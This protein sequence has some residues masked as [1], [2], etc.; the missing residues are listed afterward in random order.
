MNQNLRLSR[1][2]D[3]ALGKYEKIGAQ[4]KIE[5][6]ASSWG[7]DTASLFIMEND[8]LMDVKSPHSK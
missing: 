4:G 7:Q 2:F 8:E 1:R 6:E 3:L 5:N